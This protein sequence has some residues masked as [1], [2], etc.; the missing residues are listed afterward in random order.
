MEVS[1]FIHSRLIQKLLLTMNHLIL[2]F[3]KSLLP[4]RLCILQLISICS[5]CSTNLPKIHSFL[6]WILLSSTQ[7]FKYFILSITG[8]PSAS[9][10]ILLQQNVFYL[11]LPSLLMKCH[12]HTSVL[13]LSW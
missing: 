10:K 12:Y 8:K 5:K 13:R 4:F 3:P 11:C 6:L 2:G 9:F 7:I 1:S